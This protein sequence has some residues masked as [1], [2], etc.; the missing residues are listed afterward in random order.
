VGTGSTS[1]TRFQVTLRR[2]VRGCRGRVFS[3]AVL[4][5]RGAIRRFALQTRCVIGGGRQEPPGGGAQP[6]GGEQPGGD[7]QPVGGPCVAAAEEALFGDAGPPTLSPAF[8]AIT[9]ALDASLDGIDDDGT[10]PLDIDAVCGV[11]ANLAADGAKLVQLSGVALLS[12]STEIWTCAGAAEE[13]GGDGDAG[14]SDVP[15]KGGT[16]LQ[17]ETATA[18]LDTADT[19]FVGV[20]LVPPAGWRQDED[21]EPVPTF[22]AYWVKITD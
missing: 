13:A 2:P 1:R 8:Y 10:L 5:N 16:L 7:E 15:A 22:N 20:Q 14:C 6:G 17:G 18:A 3:R 11:P 21:G 19:A 4:R 12:P 9:F